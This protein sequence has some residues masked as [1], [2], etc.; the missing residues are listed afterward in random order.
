M[1]TVRECSRLGC[2]EPATVATEIYDPQAPRRGAWRLEH[3]DGHGADGPAIA[4]AQ[5][6]EVLSCS[7]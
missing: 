4:T 6:L 2:P 7:A 1:D 3:C 5:G